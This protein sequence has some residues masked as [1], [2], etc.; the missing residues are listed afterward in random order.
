MLLVPCVLMMGTEILAPNGWL[1]YELYDVVA[2]LLTLDKCLS[3]R[4]KY[5]S[6]EL[7]TCTSFTILNKCFLD[8]SFRPLELRWCSQMLLNHF[9]LDVCKFIY[10]GCQVDLDL[11]S[12]SILHACVIAVVYCY[13]NVLWHFHLMCVKLL[14][15]LQ[16][17]DL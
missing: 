13:I 12:T 4:R 17:F 5:R 1:V 9:V 15:F 2:T 3:L 8:L 16:G 11:L 6:L 14:L 10:R 7:L